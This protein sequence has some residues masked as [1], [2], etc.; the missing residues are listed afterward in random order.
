MRLLS[1]QFS[2][3]VISRVTFSRRWYEG[4]SWSAPRT[5][6]VLEELASEVQE[7]E[8]LF[9]FAVRHLDTP[10]SVE[11]QMEDKT[12]QFFLRNVP[13]VERME[14]DPDFLPFKEEEEALRPD[15]DADPARLIR[16]E[17]PRFIRYFSVYDFKWVQRVLN[18]TLR[19][20]TWTDRFS[21]EIRESLM[22]GLWLSNPD[23]IDIKRPDF[24][25][26][27]SDL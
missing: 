12:P 27:P 3:H 14:E 20:E 22:K 4:P 7:P 26:E 9:D 11:T 1:E 19:E 21:R 25:E 8:P 13:R 15:F 24:W 6:E 5:V 23:P 2:D 16:Y 10:A 17:R 18:K